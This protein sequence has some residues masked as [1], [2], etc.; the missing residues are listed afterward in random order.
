MLQ[1][2][3]QEREVK[4]P[5]LAGPT[6]AEQSIP[7]VNDGSSEE[8]LGVLHHPH[9]NG[10]GVRQLSV[11][12]A[13]AAL[14]G[15]AVLFASGSSNSK[16]LAASH[17]HIREALV[18]LESV[19]SSSS[20]EKKDGGNGIWNALKKVRFGPPTSRE[21]DAQVSDDIEPELSQGP[22]RICTDGW[23]FAFKTR[24]SVGLAKGNQT[25][26]ESSTGALIL[27]IEAGA[28]KK[29]SLTFRVTTFNW[30]TVQI[31]R[32]VEVNKTYDLTLSKNADSVCMDLCEYKRGQM[33]E[34]GE[35][36]LCTFAPSSM[37][38]TSFQMKKIGPLAWVEGPI[39][40]AMGF[41]Q[42][43]GSVPVSFV[44]DNV[45]FKKLYHS[46]AND[47]NALVQRLQKTLAGLAGNSVM[48]IQ[49]AV[50][51]ASAAPDNADG[52]LFQATVS[53]PE[54]EEPGFACKV[55][56]QM[57][58]WA[59]GD[60]MK[61]TAFNIAVKATT[62][63]LSFS[64]EAITLAQASVPGETMGCVTYHCRLSNPH[65]QLPTDA[66]CLGG[67]CESTCCQ[68]AWA[69]SP[70]PYHVGETTTST[71]STTKHMAQFSIQ[72]ATVEFDCFPDTCCKLIGPSGTVPL[73]RPFPVGLGLQKGEDW[74]FAPQEVHSVFS[75]QELCASNDTCTG[76]TYT[77]DNKCIFFNEGHCT[78]SETG[79][80]KW[81]YPENVCKGGTTCNAI[82]LREDPEEQ[83]VAAPASDFTMP[84]FTM[85]TVT[86]TTT[87]FSLW[88]Q[89]LYNTSLTLAE[90]ASEWAR[91][92]G[93]KIMD[94]ARDITQPIN[95]DGY[96]LEFKVDVRLHQ[97]ACL[98]PQNIL[99]SDFGT[100]VVR[101][102]PKSHDQPFACKVEFKAYL[103][104]R[105]HSTGGCQVETLLPL[106]E[107]GFYQIV[108]SRN[109]EQCCITAK[110]AAGLIGK[111]ADWYKD[112][113]GKLAEPVC[114]N[115]T[116]NVKRSE[117]QTR[118]VTEV[119]KARSPAVRTESF[120]QQTGG[121]SLSLKAVNVSFWKLK[122]SDLVNKFKDAIREAVA[123]VAGIGFHYDN[124]YPAIKQHWD[125]HA[126][127]DNEEDMD[128]AEIFLPEP[129]EEEQQSEELHQ[130]K[131]AA[132]M[133]G[134][135][136]STVHADIEKFARKSQG[137]KRRLSLFAM[138][139]NDPW[140]IPKWDAAILVQV[141]L[142]NCGACSA[143]KAALQSLV[144]A[145]VIVQRVIRA[146]GDG[147]G[148]QATVG[149]VSIQDILLPAEVTTCKA[150]QCPA[151]YAN[152]N[153]HLLCYGGSCHGTCC[154]PR[155]C[156]QVKC[157]APLV[158]TLSRAHR[159]CNSEEDC[160]EKC[161]ELPCTRYLCTGASVCPAPNSWLLTAPPAKAQQVCCREQVPKCCTAPIAWCIACLKCQTRE[162]YCMSCLF[163]WMP[164][165]IGRRLIGADS[166]DPL[167]LLP[168]PSI[169]GNDL[170]GGLPPM[171]LQPD[172][173]LEEIAEDARDAAD[174]ASIG[175]VSIATES[176]ATSGHVGAQ[177]PALR[178][179]GHSGPKAKDSI[180]KARQAKDR[181]RR[182]QS[183]QQNKLLAG[184][185]EQVSQAQA[186]RLHNRPPANIK[187]YS[188]GATT[189]EM[190][191]KT[192][193]QVILDSKAQHHGVVAGCEGLIGFPCPYYFKSIFLLHRGCGP[194]PRAATTVQVLTDTFHAVSCG[195]DGLCWIWKIRSGTPRQVF[196]PNRNCPLSQPLGPVLTVSVLPDATF[197]LSGG[198]D[199]AVGTTGSAYIWD[200]RLGFQKQ[201]YKCGGGA[202]LSS[203][204][205]IPWRQAVVGCA[206]GYS[207]IWDWDNGATVDLP[208]CARS[209]EEIQQAIGA[210]L[211]V[212][213]NF[214]LPGMQRLAVE[215][216][217][218]TEKAFME[219]VKL[220]N[221]QLVKDMDFATWIYDLFHTNR[222]G[223]VLATSLVPVRQ[224]FVTG[225]ADG[226]VL[227]W[228]S[229]SGQLL[230]V[231]CGHEGRVNAV[232]G[233]PDNQQAVSGGD[234]GTARLWS[235]STGAQLL[236]LYQ[237]SGG[238]IRSVAVI[239]GGNKVA[240]GS[241]DGY[242]RIWSLKTGVLW[243]AI[244]T[245]GGAV[246][247]LAVNPSNPLGQIIA[248]NADG[249][250]RVFNPK[251]GEI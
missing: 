222:F 217:M 44:L 178:G 122:K 205:L 18:E 47:W 231:M 61:S 171:V 54:G 5:P 26:L 135:A 247:G 34:C 238:P 21:P 249:Y 187:G 180:G 38:P 117:F 250:V 56:D 194:W 111:L 76:I 144:T 151:Y 241:D 125:H 119:Y 251:E 215:R 189:T 207:T 202:I 64:D 193:N 169:S 190:W 212:Y 228:N 66:T 223:A 15:V 86:T 239:P 192:W 17:D 136:F 60:D 230:R 30:G 213:R 96:T 35:R 40:K 154:K 39:A 150:F 51:P 188:T 67:G 128:E 139:K 214:H 248:A 210:R 107:G 1:S 74:D 183:V 123:Y 145:D 52:T 156:S 116:E 48:P 101:T 59:K 25:I 216:A 2:A 159:T 168:P 49:V 229:D 55:Q 78:I 20:G 131:L 177:A 83:V 246:R 142:I 170:S 88:Q 91:A 186:W 199:D 243:C 221:P 201:Q 206:N 11:V 113:G 121:L 143:E 102:A 115:R 200:W 99:T 127:P 181:Y 65:G 218:I 97:G 73:P 191:Q 232:A 163:K 27:K 82:R 196:F 149:K 46:S 138:K 242:I 75:C 58:A 153:P 92:T 204:P 152:N 94:N 244:N 16:E 240:L 179:G 4:G 22:T 185:M 140:K 12:C 63:D 209:A 158:N 50:N 155:F 132:L 173:T 72:G 184:M 220:G 7:L 227:Y 224:R 33:P 120:D 161:C 126:H 3:P 235:L 14:I 80:S 226:K 93:E 71:T 32:D 203:A 28:S 118:P 234:D 37:P 77:D 195:E 134:T 137:S 174:A 84:D 90:K 109:S 124:V 164:K 208:Y 70:L 129:S 245:G 104:N 53:L 105:A 157:K 147:S 106:N 103:L 133:N 57:L 9:G 110:P 31:A 225:T 98:K 112:L 43:N 165:G 148:G 130:K 166:K 211:A 141:T 100:I 62:S 219:Q 175:G 6:G 146:I 23:Q 10:F 8:E 29:P 81:R 24:L 79:S 68:P 176:A 85:P 89:V 41:A 19:S 233:L 236:M 197:I 167:M 69:D 45:P 162:A 13:V 87:E 237:P 198:A 95:S 172:V 114:V 160:G 182:L 108:V 42:V 36:H